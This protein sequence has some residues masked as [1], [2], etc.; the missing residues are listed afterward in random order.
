MYALLMKN[1]H[2]IA[3]LYSKLI[4][5][6]TSDF[7]LCTSDCSVY[8]TERSDC[9]G[10]CSLKGSCKIPSEPCCP[11]LFHVFYCLWLLYFYGQIN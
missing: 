8:V 7:I 1:I 10:V 4:Y 11:A 9:N 3:C 6:A 2:N 5:W